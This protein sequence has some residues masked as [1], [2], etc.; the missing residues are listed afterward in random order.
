MSTAKPQKPKKA[1]IEVKSALPYQTL[2]AK[3]YIGEIDDS[4]AL[5]FG[6]L[7]YSVTKLWNTALWYCKEQWEATGKIPNYN[8]I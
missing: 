6:L 4:T 3:G 1:E 5:Q 8:D 7:G 2:T